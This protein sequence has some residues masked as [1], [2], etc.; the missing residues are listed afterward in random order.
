MKNKLFLEAKNKIDGKKYF[1][2]QKAYDNYSAL[3][4]FRDFALLDQQEKQL[5]WDWACNPTNQNKKLLDEV[6]SKKIAVAV[7]HGY[8]EEDLTP[9]YSCKICGDTG[10]VNGKRCVCLER[11]INAL[12]RRECDLTCEN[13]TF[14][15]SLESHPHNKQVYDACQKYCQNIDN[16]KILNVFL[17]GQTG[18]GKTYLCSAMANTLLKAGKTVLFV[19]A[20]KLNNDFL[21]AHT[22]FDT[23][24][25]A[26]IE[27]YLQPDVLI[28]DDLGTEPIY[29]NVTKEYLFALLNERLLAKR[30]TIVCTN[31]MFDQIMD[32]YDERISSR[33]QAQA[34]KV[35][36]ESDDKRVKIAK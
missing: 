34:L 29:K 24:K 21:T 26:V 15:A 22:S 16:K 10:F 9:Q 35:K 17:T 30:N 5:S 6:S 8:K 36:L 31:L 23:D 14:E 19:S 18:T 20:F 13:C 27:H 25:L 1:A 7:A 3:L 4:S 11:E 33:L 32:L 28:I 12:I 2:E